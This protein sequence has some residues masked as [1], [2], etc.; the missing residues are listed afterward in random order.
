MKLR[1]ALPLL[2]LAGCVLTVGLKLV[3]ALTWPWL[4]V[5]APIWG[6]AP[7]CM[8]LFAALILSF[9]FLSMFTVWDEDAED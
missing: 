5:T 3:G 4:W 8:T 1:I 9:S 6:F 2:Y 7:V